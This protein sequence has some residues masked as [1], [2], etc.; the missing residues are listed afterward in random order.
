MSPSADLKFF[1]VIVLYTKNNGSLIKNLGRGT[2]LKI[3]ETLPTILSLILRVK[4]R[5]ILYRRIR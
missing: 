3:G 4:M 1:I 5:L 2:E